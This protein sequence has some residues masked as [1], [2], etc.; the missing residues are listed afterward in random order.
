[1]LW[2]FAGL[3]EVAEPAAL[4]LSRGR[5]LLPLTAA[6]FNSALRGDAAPLD[7]A[8][9]RLATLACADLTLEQHTLAMFWQVRRTCMQQGGGNKHVA[10]SA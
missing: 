2:F 7:V 3:A 6:H 9:W 1:V 8:E 5:L 10:Q 4:A